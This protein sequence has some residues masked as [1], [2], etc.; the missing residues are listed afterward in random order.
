MTL[1]AFL[2]G[3]ALEGIDVLPDQ[4]L[5]NVLVDGQSLYG[6][7]V[8]DVPE[9]VPLTRYAPV[10][11]SGTTIAADGMVFDTTQYEML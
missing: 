4:R 3:K 11:L 10:S 8:E 7:V 9:N 2:V 1:D 6:V 5:L